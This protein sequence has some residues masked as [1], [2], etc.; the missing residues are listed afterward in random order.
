[1]GLIDLLRNTIL[2]EEKPR[3]EF[4]RVEPGLIRVEVYRGGEKFT[5]SIQTIPPRRY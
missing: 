1:M 2:K 5:R 3:V 4:Y